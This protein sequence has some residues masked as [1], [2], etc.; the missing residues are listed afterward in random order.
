MSG[1]HGGGWRLL[2]NS[3][4]F[5]REFL[6]R[7]HSSDSVVFCIINRCEN[8]AP[9]AKLIFAAQIFRQSFLDFWKCLDDT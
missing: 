3:K 5:G 8:F 6:D 2:P 4:I 1:G 9:V 7:S